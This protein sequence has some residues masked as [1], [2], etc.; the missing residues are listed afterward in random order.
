MPM[1]P[2]ALK[3]TGLR[4]VENLGTSER[5]QDLENRLSLPLPLIPCISLPT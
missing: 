5:A 4:V 2:N 3:G 1:L